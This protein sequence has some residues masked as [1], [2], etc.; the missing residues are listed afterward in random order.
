MTASDAQQPFEGITVLDLG[1]YY[2]APYAGLLLALGGADV[3]K[4]ESLQGE[5]MRR[6]DKR[7]S[8]A[9]AMLNSNKR[10]I[11]CNLKHLFGNIHAV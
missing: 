8:F 2:Q 4:V 3:V 1:Q 5:P 9:Q 7:A 10:A 11:S 6:P